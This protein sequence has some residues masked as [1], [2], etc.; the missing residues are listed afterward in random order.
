[1]RLAPLTIRL[2]P[3]GVLLALLF[4]SSHYFVSSPSEIVFS[5]ALIVLNSTQIGFSSTQGAVNLFLFPFTLRLVP[6][7]L[8]L[9]L[10][11]F[12]SFTSLRLV[13]IMLFL[14]QHRLFVVPPLGS[15]CVVFSSTPM[16]SHVTF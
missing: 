2:V 6:L 12:R 5:S 9:V 14:A 10:L 15:N 1:M 11:L 4:F 8:F 13:P 7:R 3:I 16:F